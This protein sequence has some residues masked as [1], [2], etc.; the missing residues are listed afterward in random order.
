MK[1]QFIVANWKSHKTAAEAKDWL[2][3]YHLAI[4]QFPIA[5]EKEIILCPPFP[6]LPICFDFI[7]KHHLTLLLG[8]QTISSYPEGTYT[9]EVS[10]RLLKDFVSYTLIGHS[11]RRK[12][13]HE[14]DT[15]MTAKVQMAKA[16]N[17]TPIL[18]IGNTEELVPAGVKIVVYE[19]PGAI[20]SAAGQHPDNPQDVARVADIIA[21]KNSVSYILY[22]GSVTAQNVATFT[23][24]PEI[25]GVIVGGE[26]LDGKA[27]AQI[28]QNS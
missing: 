7:Q 2:E 24:L 22:G 27:F 16:H 21:T 23:Q 20:S 11:E 3:A 25:S 5:D 1:K 12:F 8:S 14:T 18:L 17:I 4:S 10:A 9:G 26:S 13:F 19:P 6:L 28:A 15:D